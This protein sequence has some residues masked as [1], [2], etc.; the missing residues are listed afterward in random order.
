MLNIG[1]C[2]GVAAVGGKIYFEITSYYRGVIEFNG[3]EGL[4]IGIEEV[5]IYTPYSNFSW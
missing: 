2:Y 3:K 5:D 1:K 4:E